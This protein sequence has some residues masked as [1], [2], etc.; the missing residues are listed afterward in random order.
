MTD[1][2]LCNICEGNDVRNNL[3]ALKT[4][5]ADDNAVS[6]VKQDANYSE[7][8]FTDLLH[9][10]DAKIRKN[11]ALIMGLLNEESFAPIIY[12]AYM[13]EE[14]LFVKSAY[15]K[16]LQAYDYKEY[17]DWLL[18]RKEEL[19]NGS[20]GDGD[21]KHVA[22]ELKELKKMFPDTGSYVKHVFKNPKQP[23]RVVLTAGKEMRELLAKQ[24]A[25]VT[26]EEVTEVFCGV[27][28]KTKDIDKLSNIRIYRE[29]LYP[30]NGMRPCN[31]G[32]L[33]S[34]ILEGNLMALIKLLH[35]EGETVYRFRIASST[36]DSAK[37]ARELEIASGG[38]LVNSISDYEIELR[39]MEGKDGKI[40]AFVKLYTKADRRFTYRKNNVATS[41]HPVKAASIVEICAPFL[42]KNIQTL[43]PFCGVGT[44]LIER[45][46]YIKAKYLYGTDIYGD[47][48]EGGRENAELAG[49]DINFIRRDFFDFE[50]EYPFDEIITEMPRLSHDE[51]DDFY[52]R[53]FDKSGELLK[54]NGL[55]I[56]YSEERGILMKQL[57]L[58][59][60]FGM[61]YEHLMDSKEDFYV[62]V[63]EKQ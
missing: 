24:V 59:K 13:S 51:A 7:A 18:A 30:L 54:K 1:K 36:L 11:T 50:H 17:E 34:Y 29:M 8:L 5:L 31:K 22:E 39:F 47:A 14:T 32:E 42:K 19:Q 45:N 53:F 23:V 3:I 12:N 58:H 46:R 35:A 63:M 56:V 38:R 33:I 55:I 57:R 48:I 43:D 4:E 20:Y 37:L 60:E 21:L 10:E 27:M 52:R 15:L 25:S 41:L 61:V 44:L 9:N 28:V 40:L 16:A 26:G 2:I 62:Y 6:A 49:A